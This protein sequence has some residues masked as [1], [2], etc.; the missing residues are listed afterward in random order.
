V[1]LDDVLLELDAK[2]QDRFRA[3]FAD[4]FGGVQTIE[5]ATAVPA[6]GNA[7]E[8]HVIDLDQ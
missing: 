2:H 8:R 6:A 3:F 7:E 4:R 1:L 5:T